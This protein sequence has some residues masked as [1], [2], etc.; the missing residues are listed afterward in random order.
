VNIF[1]QSIF[2]CPHSIG[3]MLPAFCR[4]SLM[5]FAGF[6]V[7]LLPHAVLLSFLFLFFGCYCAV[8]PVI[9]SS[10]PYSDWFYLAPTS[11]CN[12]P[13]GPC[14]DLVLLLEGLGSHLFVL[15]FWLP[16]AI[17]EGL[18]RSLAC[19]VHSRCLSSVSMSFSESIVLVIMDTWSNIWWGFD[20]STWH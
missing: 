13:G 16:V 4:N 7:N 10:L 11:L 9:P 19:I 1:S 6:V 17:A 20:F 2:N 15:V 3:R 14:S 18:M 8:S 5:V 12:L